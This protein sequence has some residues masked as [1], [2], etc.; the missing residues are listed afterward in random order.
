MPDHLT[1]KIVLITGAAGGFGQALTWAFL[2]EGAHLALLDSNA[3]ALE[4]LATTLRAQGGQVQATVA[5]LS[6][7]QGVQQGISAVLV[8]YQNQVDVFIG[9]VGVL[10][11]G[12]FEQISEAQIT[13][14]FTMNFLTHVWACREVL[15]RMAGREG[16]NIV[17]MG[18]D[19]GHQPD[20]GLFPYA[21]AKAALHSFAK[22]LAREY[23]PA[24]RVNVVAPGMSR[25]RMVETLMEQVAVKFQT[26]RASAEYLELQRRGIPLRRL[27]TP[28][29]IAEA[30]VFLAGNRFCTGSTLDISGGNG[31]GL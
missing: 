1:N 22:I 25:T 9:N 26:D 2:E 4:T 27:G 3:Q 21:S 5:D 11:A 24:I 10:V 28:E 15:P 20:A 14:G 23:G 6:T 30:V 7:V 13:H 19:Q 8:P 12:S 31:R 29:E 16:A 18:S 17:L